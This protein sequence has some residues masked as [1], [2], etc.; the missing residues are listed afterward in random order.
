MSE[1]GLRLKHAR[2]E[3][4]YT[5]DELQTITKIQKRYLIAIEEGD[6]SRLP[7]DFYAR[8]FVKSYADAVGIPS[9]VL[10][11][12]HQTDLPSPKQETAELPPRV[13]RSKP[14]LVRRRSKFA[15]LLPT[16]I[17]VIFVIAVVAGIWMFGQD[18]K[19]DSPGVSREES[20][21][22]PEVDI[23]DNVT[24]NTD[25]NDGNEGDTA[26]TEGDED[27]EEPETEAEQSLA[28]ERTE[29]GNRSYFT[30][31]NTD[32]FEVRMEFSGDS[33]VRLIDPND[34]TIHEQTYR[35]GDEDSFDLSGETQVTFHLG[36]APTA[37]IYINDE[38][39]E[40][41]IDA[42]TQRIIVQFDPLNND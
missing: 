17:A 8:A 19:D 32:S 26:E 31:S 6:Y 12:E 25:D 41:P 14:K 42:T 29:E 22:E 21:N 1:L 18:N 23:T 13:T 3:K 33:W 16:L 15:S 27:E 9:E 24:D 35:N 36:A 30:L 28:F 20:Q 10:F 11:E 4:G 5:L 38:L 40:Y 37:N 7:G 2:E 34:Q 39:L